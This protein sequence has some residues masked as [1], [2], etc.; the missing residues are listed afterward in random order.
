MSAFSRYDDDRL[1][2]ALAAA[3]NGVAIVPSL[4]VDA[5]DDSVRVL[6]LAGEPPPRIIVL[7]EHRDAV[8]SSAAREFRKLALPICQQLLACDRRRTTGKQVGQIK[9]LPIRQE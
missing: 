2:Q 6:E 1:I 4:T 3:G 7:V 5:T 9:G 8:L